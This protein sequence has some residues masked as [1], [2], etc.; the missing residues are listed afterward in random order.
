MDGRSES[1]LTAKTPEA[2]RYPFELSKSTDN[3]QPVYT[4]S[5]QDSGLHQPV[6]SPKKTGIRSTVG[7]CTPPSREDSHAG[8]TGSLGIQATYIEEFAG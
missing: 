5:R 4:P 1:T 2:V 3:H 7:L 6:Y 8:R